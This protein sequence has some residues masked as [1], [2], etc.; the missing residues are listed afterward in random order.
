MTIEAWTII[1][2]AIAFGV[3]LWRIS[4]RLDARI[5]RFDARIDRL[6][7]RMTADIRELRSSIA[8]IDRRLAGLEAK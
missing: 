8:D 7:D 2:C 3:F 5:D 4:V 1:G 6:E